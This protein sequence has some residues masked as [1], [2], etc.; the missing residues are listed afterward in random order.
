M[1]SIFFN[2]KTSSYEV[3]FDF[4]SSVITRD[5]QVSLSLTKEI[6]SFHEVNLKANKTRKMKLDNILYFDK[7]GNRKMVP[8]VKHSRAAT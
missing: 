5:D 8:T 7:W 2:Y 3:E 1:Q 6:K 4:N